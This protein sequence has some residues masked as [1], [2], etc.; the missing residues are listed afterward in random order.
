AS[1]A[2]RFDHDPVARA[3]RGV[4]I[5]AAAGHIS[6]QTANIP[7]WAGASGT[8]VNRTSYFSGGVA[9]EHFGPS[10][11]YRSQQYTLAANT[12]YRSDA[13]VERGVGTNAP[14]HFLMGFYR[15]TP[16]WISSAY[17]YWNGIFGAGPGA[18]A[19]SGHIIENLGIGPNGGQMFRFSCVVQSGEGGSTG[20]F[21]YPTATYGSV[22][23]QSAIVHYACV[24]AGTPYHSPSI[25]GT[26]AQTRA[27]DSLSMPLPIVPAD[28]FTIAFRARMPRV[29]NSTDTNVLFS[30]LPAASTADRITVDSYS[31][32]GTVWMGM[33]PSG[34]YRL[35]MGV[36]L[37]G[38][39]YGAIS[40]SATQGYRGSVLGGA[41]IKVSTLPPPVAALT[42]IAL[43]SSAGAAPWGS[44][45]KRLGIWPHGDFSD[46]AM[47][48]LLA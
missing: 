42:R 43:G 10:S 48:G 1:G 27:S 24:T 34:L 8:N 32:V 2:P 47:R 13:I 6:T 19:S 31:G 15:N 39:F 11:G 12:S 9:V 17:F 38:E 44:T 30:L 5:E 20:F 37:G 16:G 46:D 29:N 14:P 35:A 23:G 25:I 26:S 41:V 21:F 18:L 4:L 33:P 22:A 3:P 7:A 28:G 36:P 45:I 40:W